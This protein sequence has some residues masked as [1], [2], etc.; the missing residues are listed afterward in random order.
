MKLWIGVTDEGWYEFLRLLNPDEV[1]FWQPGGGRQFRA[2]QPGEPFLFKLHSP[3]NY[4]VGGGF[5]V[6]FSPLPCSLA[7]EAFGE[8]NGVRSYAEFLARIRKYR[9][10][11]GNANRVEPDPVVGCNV[12][13]QPFFFP[14]QLWIPV[15]EDWS[16]NIVQGKTYDT[17]HE[18]GRALWGMVKE[19]ALSHDLWPSEETGVVEDNE[20]PKYL[21]AGRLGQGAFRILVTDAYQRRCAITGERTLPVLEAAHI[22]PYSDQG[23][24]VICNGLLLRSDL[25]KLFDIGYLTVTPDYHVEISKRIR[26]EYANGHQYYAH[27]GQGLAVL[28]QSADEQP[29]K[30]F[31]DW[32][33]QS[34]FVP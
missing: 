30:E 25:H 18:A 29:S 21:V 9:V 3:K 7:W 11:S 14:E 2:L 33:N 26:E 20:R 13:A 23:P 16:P 8:K 6:R 22:R 15:P 27:H 32:H 34:I 1:N 19:I 12:L 4:I 28:P 24:N 10:A 31:L 17:E 5:F